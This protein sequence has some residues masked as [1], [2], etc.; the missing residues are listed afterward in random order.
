MPFKEI[1][2]KSIDE[3]SIGDKA[4]FAKTI[5]ETDIYQFSAVTGDF[6]PAHVNEVY[7]SN[8]FFKKRIAHGMLTVSLVS[9]I[10]GTQLPGPGTIFVSESVEFMAP[11][12]I[13]D[14]IEAVVEIVEIN[15]EKNR[16]KFEAFCINQ[17]DKK[18][19]RAEGIVMPPKKRKPVEAKS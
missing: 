4:W 7:A 11:V 1:M 5:S 13:H 8:T 18:V 9:N 15:L 3:L 14:T 10:L 6:N 12:Y 2:G 17:H 16:V 19:L